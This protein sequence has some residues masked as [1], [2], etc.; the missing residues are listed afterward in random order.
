MDR[1]GNYMYLHVHVNHL[2]CSTAGPQDQIQTT[3]QTTHNDLNTTPDQST[4][5]TDNEW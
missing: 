2:S 4:G 5:S 1:H 3:W